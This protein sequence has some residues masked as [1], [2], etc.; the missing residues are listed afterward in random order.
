MAIIATVTKQSVSLCMPK[1]WYIKLN[2]TLIDGGIEVLSKDY[3]VKYKTGGSIPSK[4]A[5]FIVRM[6]ADIDKYKSEQAIYKSAAL[7]TAVTGIG[8]ALEV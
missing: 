4:K 1:L 3:S 2:L 6:Q 8:N 5:E 7:N